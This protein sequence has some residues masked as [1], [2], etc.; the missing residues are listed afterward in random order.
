MGSGLNRVALYW[1]C[2]HVS[3]H[4]YYIPAIILSLTS[5][6]LSIRAAGRTLSSL[7]FKRLLSLNHG[8]DSKIGSSW[9]NQPA[10]SN[11]KMLKL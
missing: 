4:Y 10:P 3:Y 7:S 1:Y 9:P 2:V 8:S 5:Y 6:P 11:R